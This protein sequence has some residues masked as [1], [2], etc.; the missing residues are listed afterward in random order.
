MRT[1]V[2]LAGR[3][4]HGKDTAAGYFADHGFVQLRFADP[5]KAML[6]AFYRT[7]GLGESEIER[8]IEGD[9]KEVPCPYLRG[10][11]PRYAMQ[12]LG[13]EWG[14]CLIADDLW[15]SLLVTRAKT[16]DKVVVS[17]TRYPNECGA[18]VDAG[19]CVLRIDAG[20]R[21]PANELSNHSSEREVDALPVAGAV[22]NSG[23]PA[24]LRQRIRA[25]VQEDGSLLSSGPK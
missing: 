17:D 22:D 25:L 12:T 3:K 15:V 16:F 20:P 24:D 21:V 9:L 7:A 8:R 13:T 1:L 14:R 2:G 10:K 4:Y 23:S 19:G 6:R 5:L 18:I 11:T